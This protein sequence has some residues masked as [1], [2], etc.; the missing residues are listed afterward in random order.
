MPTGVP[1]RDARQQLFDSAERVLLRDGANG[2]TSRAVTAEA[3]VAKG[4]V[5][6]H[7]ADFDALL[8]ELVLDR[9]TRVEEQTKVLVDSAGT[10]TV[11]DN[12][13][14]ALVELFSP[15]ALA[16]V[17]LVI[18]RDSL[19]ERLRQAG[20]ARIP[21][22][23]HGAQMV[24]SYLAAERD[25][26]RIAAEADLQTLAPSLIGAVHM[27]YTDYETVPVTRTD[28]YRVVTAV[29]GNVAAA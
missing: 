6:R 22:L 27:L 19:R 28:V 13:T 12:L 20:S 5:H 7:F 18:S 2:L 9:I 21:L 15:V 14:D 16:I 29:I 26:S 24:K 17:G 11:A 1:I 3:G 4:L 8:A 10:G 25:R 23:T